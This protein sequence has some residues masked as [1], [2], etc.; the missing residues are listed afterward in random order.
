MTMVTVLMTHYNAPDY[1]GAAVASVLNQSFRDL[2]LWLLDDASPNARW[3]EVLEPYRS[4]SRLRLFRATRNVGTY[5]LKNAAIRAGETA[6]VA[7][8]DADDISH[9]RRLALQVAAARKGRAAIVGSS[10]LTMDA[11]GKV[12][13]ARFLPPIANPFLRL[14]KSYCCL[15]PTTLVAREVFDLIGGFD[16]ST[17]FGAD[18]D[19]FYRAHH[20]FRIRNLVRPLYRYRR[21]EDSLSGAEDTGHGSPARAAYWATVKAREAERRWA[22]ARGTAPDLSAPTLPM[23]FQL[24]ELVD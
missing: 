8:H 16:E 18:S 1:L 17:R 19:F 7:F 21:H 15:H 10:F 22:V 6:L 12:D 5:R 4:D 9:P 20:R 23:D 11:G 24:Q 3:R 14:G 13:G 2:E